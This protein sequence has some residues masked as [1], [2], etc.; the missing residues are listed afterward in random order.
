MLKNSKIVIGKISVKVAS[1]YYKIYAMTSWQASEIIWDTRKS[2][3]L[4]PSAKLDKNIQ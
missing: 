4:R 3:H 1:K 2:L